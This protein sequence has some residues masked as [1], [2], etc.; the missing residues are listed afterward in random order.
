MDIIIA[1]ILIFLF[2]MLYLAVIFLF[3]RTQKNEVEVYDEVR[4]P[5]VMQILVPRENDKTPLA[6]EQMFASIRCI[7]GDNSRSLDLISFEI[8]S[9][10]NDGIKFYAVIPKHLAKFIEGQIYAQYPNADIRYVQDYIDK[11]DTDTQL[12]LLLER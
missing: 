7:L 10:G 8:A 9:S 5:L 4:N 6:A 1:T 3:K 2:V 11:K 12:L